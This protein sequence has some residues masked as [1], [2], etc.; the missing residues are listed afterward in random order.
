MR[1]CVSGHTPER[2]TRKG[3][4]M[5]NLIFLSGLCTSLASVVTGQDLLVSDPIMCGMIE[6]GEDV[7]EAGT[8]LKSTGM[9]EIEYYCEFDRQVS[10][11]VA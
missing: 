8:T 10:L 3:V 4:I 2:D 7:Q 11:L 1:Y 6:R 5:R 9:Y